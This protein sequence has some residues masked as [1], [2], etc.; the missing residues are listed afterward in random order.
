[1]K[2]KIDKFVIQIRYLNLQITFLQT[3]SFPK[4]DKISKRILRAS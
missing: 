2:I 1:M 4:S 3:I